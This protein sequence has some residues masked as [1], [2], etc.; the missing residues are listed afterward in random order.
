LSAKIVTNKRAKQKTQ[1]IQLKPQ[2]E[3]E[4]CPKSLHTHTHT[5]IQVHTHKVSVKIKFAMLLAFV[6][7]ASGKE[8]AGCQGKETGRA[9][10]DAKRME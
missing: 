10:T 7:A 5:Q 9:M 8:T 2:S 3:E 1:Q 4:A 6:Y